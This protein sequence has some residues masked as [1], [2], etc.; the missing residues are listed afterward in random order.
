MKKHLT[1]TLQNFQGYQKRNKSEKLSEPRGALGDIYIYICQTINIYIQTI[2]TLWMGG[3]NRKLHH[4]KTKR[5]QSIHFSE[6][7][8]INMVH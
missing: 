5:T 3:W 4:V 6:Y 8:Y 1:S 2:N 7:Y